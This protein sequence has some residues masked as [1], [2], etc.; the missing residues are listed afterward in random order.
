MLDAA[1]ARRLK[2]VGFDV[3]GVLTDN[4]IY[5]G[6]VGDHP[7]EFKRFHI[8]DG[9]GVR[10][11]RT[12]GLLVVW[13]SGRE[14]TAT[15]LRARE[16]AVDEVIQD[17]TARKLPVF[18]ALLERRGLAWEEC[19]FV[20][21]DLADLPLLTRV[22]L[23][24]AVANGV[25]EVKAAAR[26]VT[27][28][29]GGQGAV[30]E[31]AELI[32]KARGEWQ[33][34][35]TKYFLER[36]DVPHGAQR[37]RCARARRAGAR[38]RCDPSGRRA[39]G[40]RLLGR[41][42]AA[43]EGHRPADRLRHRQ[44]GTDR[45]QD[46]GYAHLHRQPRLVPPSGGLAAWRPGPRRERG[47]RHPALEERRLRRAVRPRGSAQAARRTDHCAHG[48]SGLTARSPVRRRPRCQRHGGGVPRDAGAYHQHHGSA[49][50]R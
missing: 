31:V 46:R 20:G 48:G 38:G 22:G 49:G 9:L 25:T 1:V 27:T 16:L 3:D 7:V 41:R 18:E 13:L 23:P 11:L 37:A 43:R 33:G 47:R 50:A 14:S 10:L 21:D 39:P 28:V 5:V 19:A 45:A 35:L 24:I 6:M 34:L 44:V 40:P 4:G 8:Q 12:A 15:M 36:G 42:A 32:L 17:P 30:R 2:L 29:P 26:V